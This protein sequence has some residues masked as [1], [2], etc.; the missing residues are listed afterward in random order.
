MSSAR[1]AAASGLATAHAPALDLPARF[2]A[3]GILVLAGVAITAPWTLPVMLGSFYAPPLLAFVHVNTL[4]IIGAVILGASYQLTPVIL[5]IPLVSVGLARFSF[6]CYL[7]GI[8]ALPLG[9]FRN[10]F[11]ALLV[12]GTLLTLAF[13]LAAGIIG[14]TF[15]RAP[16]RDVVAWH[17]VTAYVGAI[18]G[19]TYGL[20]LAINKGTGFLGGDT[21]DNLA[22]HA[23][24]MLGGWVAVLLTGVAYRLVGM[25]TLAEDALWVPG[26]WL[27]LIALSGGA[28]LLSTNL[29]LAGPQSLNIAGTAALLAGLALFAG[30]LGRLYQRRRRR[31]VDV[32]MP[33]ILAATG[34]GLAATVLLLIGFVTGRPLTDPIWVA[35]GWLAIAGLAETAIQGFF[36]KISTFLVWLHRYAPLAGKQRLPRLEDL[37][38]RR[39]AFTGCALW[40]TAVPLQ[41]VAILTGARP[42]STLAGVLLAAGLA[43]FLINVVT[44]GR[45]WRGPQ[46][47]ADPGRAPTPFAAPTST[48]GAASAAAATVK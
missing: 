37:Y 36:Y 23:A 44:I 40:V 48:Q 24:I 45:H 27:A 42:L 18:G 15:R 19:V 28:W 39:L 13:L 10:W 2:L 20:I 47:Q 22:A 3:V 34:F 31:G 14:A 7:G 9:L 35:A 46:T 32:H 17:L 11:P 25:F 12:G 6:W 16:Q 1:P 29:H 43:C 4:G 38:H 41:T 8:V 30:Q 26:A 5:Q 21:L 33:F